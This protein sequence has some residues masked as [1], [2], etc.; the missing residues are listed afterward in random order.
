MRIP[1][2]LRPEQHSGPLRAVVKP[3]IESIAGAEEAHPLP[4]P[5]RIIHEFRDDR[6]EA[7]KMANRR[8]SYHSRRPM[9]DEP[10]DAISAPRKPQLDPGIEYLVGGRIPPEAKDQRARVFVIGHSQH[11][12]KDH[13]SPLIRSRSPMARARSP[14]THSCGRAIDVLWTQPQNMGIVD[15]FFERP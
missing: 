6:V 3:G 13:C 9:P 12:S 8:A 15:S 10:D 11:C 1:D 2:R 14:H 7:R 4:K 5:A